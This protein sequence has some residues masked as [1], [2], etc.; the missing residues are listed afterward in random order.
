M[1]NLT[2]HNILVRRDGFVNKKDS[3]IILLN[4]VDNMDIPN[5]GI[6]VAVGPGTDNEPMPYRRG[7]RVQ[8]NPHSPV[9]HNIEGEDLLLM[10]TDDVYI[11]LNHE[12]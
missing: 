3:G 11:I 1:I 9:E 5:T 4:P 6:I 7:Q 10:Q 2:K 12:A 8:F